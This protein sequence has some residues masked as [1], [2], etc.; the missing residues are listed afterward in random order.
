MSKKRKVLLI[1]VLILIFLLGLGM[2]VYPYLSAQY[3][4]K[5]QSEIHTTYQEVVE[6][7][8][9]QARIDAIRQAA[10]EYNHKL[11]SGLISPLTPTENGYFE[12]LVV[13]GSDIMC[14][15]RIPA[16]DVS[17]PVYHGIG[18]EEL[19]IG[20]GHMPQT[21]LPIG[22][23]N[24]H[25][26]LSAHTGMASNP[27]FTDLGLLEEGDLV[28]IDVLGETL[29]YQVYDTPDPVLPNAIS[30]VKIQQG[31]DLLTLVTCT[32]ININTHRL[33]VHCERIEITEEEPVHEITVEDVTEE[34]T[35]LY[36]EQ[37]MKNIATGGI[38]GL[39]I[40][41]LSIVF[42]LIKRNKSKKKDGSNE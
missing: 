23:E 38:I 33:L 18:D 5:V 40:I 12:Q 16:I 1:I 13:E 27:M 35:S 31:K 3:A 41:L 6:D 22:G 29:T 42:V 39:I 11:Y 20:A 37:M 28:Y 24:T 15:L 7:P 14:Y 19:N 2:M 36:N 26:V 10:I 21:S 25:A 9:E 8:E 30:T 32:P 4:E 17:L 34:K